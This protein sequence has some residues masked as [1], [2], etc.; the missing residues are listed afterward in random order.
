VHREGTG[1]DKFL[2]QGRWIVAVVEQKGLQQRISRGG[3]FGE[4]Y[5]QTSSVPPN[6]LA[7]KAKEELSF[8]S[9]FPNGQG[10]GGRW[11]GR[12]RCHQEYPGQAEIPAL[13]EDVGGAVKAD[14]DHVLKG[15]ASIAASIDHG[16]WTSLGV[17]YVAWLRLSQCCRII[18]K[19]GAKMKICVF[20][21]KLTEG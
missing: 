5:R 13:T 17:F 15:D 19:S 3:H 4:R 14:S 18:C 12:V 8:R 7:G 1:T 2:S 20:F 6:D 21:V 9:I 10:A 11:P 16:V